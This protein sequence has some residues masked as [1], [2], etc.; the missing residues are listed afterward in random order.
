MLPIALVV[1]AQM[2]RSGQI[3]GTA[4]TAVPVDDQGGT[5]MCQAVRLRVVEYAVKVGGQDVPKLLYLAT[6]LGDGD[7]YPCFAVATSFL[8]AD[9]VCLAVSL[10]ASGHRTSEASRSFSRIQISRALLSSCPFSTPC[11]AQVGSE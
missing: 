10:A 9:P 1:L 4:L 2:A 3:A 5:V 7:V 8:P 6:D 11:L